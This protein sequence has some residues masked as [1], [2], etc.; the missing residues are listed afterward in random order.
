MDS[1]VG[2]IQEAL[3]QFYSFFG[4]MQNLK[5]DIEML[6]DLDDVTRNRIMYQL[7]SIESKLSLS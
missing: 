6:G 7:D 2:C 5:N 3:A 1:E 4:T